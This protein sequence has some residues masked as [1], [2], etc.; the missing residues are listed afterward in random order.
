MSLPFLDGKISYN[1]NI[2]LNCSKNLHVLYVKTNLSN[3]IFYLK[4][5]QLSYNF[6]E[7]KKKKKSDD[8][9]CYYIKKMAYPL[10]NLTRQ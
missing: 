3:L 1:P 6:V 2:V 4:N 10:L 7:V 9:T 5:S 8:M